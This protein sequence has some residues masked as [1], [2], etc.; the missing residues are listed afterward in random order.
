MLMPS[1]LD[2]SHVRVL[3]DVLV[4]IKAVLGSFSLAQI[5]RQFDEKNHHRL[6]RRDGSAASPLGGDMFVKDSKSGWGLA[7]SDK[8]PSP[9]Q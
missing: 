5:N 2:G 4:L 7:D 3:G 1:Y 6:Q 8:F 9:L